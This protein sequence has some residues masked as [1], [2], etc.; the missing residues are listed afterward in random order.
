ME[1]QTLPSFSVSLDCL[2]DFVIQYKSFIYTLIN[3]ITFMN[4]ANYLNE[5]FHT[6]TYFFVVLTIVLFLFTER[7]ESS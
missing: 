2:Y 1:T 7:A 4:L 6:F 5:P 3:L